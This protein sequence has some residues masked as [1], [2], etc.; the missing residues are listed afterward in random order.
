MPQSES[1]AIK[2]VGVDVCKQ[3]LDIAF[4]GGGVTRIKRTDAKW[5][6]WLKQVGPQE[7]HV[8][9]E[10]TGGLE[11]LVADACHAL[12]VTYS[13][14]NP[15]R[16]RQFAKATGRLAKTDRI[17]AE[18]LAAFGRATR[19]R[20]SQPLSPER[21]LLRAQVDRRRDLVQMRTGEKNRL[22][23]AA[24][25]CRED[26][27]EHITWLNE[28]FTELDDS[29]ARATVD[30]DNLKAEAAQLRSVKGVGPVTAATLL[31]LLPELGKLD[32]RQIAALVG[33]APFSNESGPRR[34]H[35]RIYGGRSAVRSAL[36]MSAL[37][38]RCN[39][40]FRATY[41][42]LIDAKKPV[43]VALTAIARKLL[44]VL[45]AMVRDGTS[46]Q[47]GLLVEPRNA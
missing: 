36:Y 18:V 19:P 28:A 33:L 25:L 16:V 23:Q 43:K 40:V 46:W 38:S 26:I 20:A 44:T 35:R 29:I 17:D 30:D 13:I 3:W 27:Q 21:V 34:A 31:A 12:S 1:R 24:E 15:L 6:Q 14:V 37:A 41:R 45:N 39:P 4:E 42:R 47:G 9:V 5:R 22:K 11:A 8:V 7:V 2:F 32:R 10:A